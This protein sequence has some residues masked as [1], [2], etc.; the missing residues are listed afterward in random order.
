MTP[1]QSIAG[2]RIVQRW[3]RIRRQ[4][5]PRVPWSV[6]DFTPHKLTRFPHGTHTTQHGTT[7][8]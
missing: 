7:T 3:S 1:Q 2:R 6:G 5:T 4:N 8:V